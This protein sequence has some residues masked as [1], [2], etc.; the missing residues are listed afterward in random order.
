VN[1]AVSAEVGFAKVATPVLDQ[2]VANWVVVPHFSLFVP[3]PG[4]L[5]LVHVRVTAMASV[6]TLATMPPATR[7]S[8]MARAKKS[9]VFMKIPLM[10]EKR[11][12][13][14]CS[15]NLR[16]LRTINRNLP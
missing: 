12:K 8:A 14:I 2:L 15:K 3:A 16:N 10:G 1:T 5:P 4:A 13:Q 6:G 11:A 7:A 9:L